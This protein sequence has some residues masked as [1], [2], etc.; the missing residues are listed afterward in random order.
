MQTRL[1]FSLLGL[2]AGIACAGHPGPAQTRLPPPEAFAAC[3]GKTEG[4]AVKISLPDQRSLEASCMKA[5]DK[6]AARP[7]KMPA[8]HDGAHEPRHDHAPGHPPMLR[9]PFPSFEAIAACI[10][11]KD[12]ETIAATLPDGQKLSS[13]CA[14]FDQTLALRPLAPPPPAPASMPERKQP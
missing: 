4:A 1:I 8:P 12:G 9:P 2:W 13:Q 6:L 11:K 7:N 10:G 5:G 3:E 14:L